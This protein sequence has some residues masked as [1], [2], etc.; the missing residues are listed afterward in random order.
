MAP[1]RTNT[2][3]LGTAWLSGMTS[4]RLHGG[5]RVAPGRECYTQSGAADLAQI[6]RPKGEQPLQDLRTDI[7]PAAGESPRRRPQ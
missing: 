7:G 1:K 4:P 5:E 3:G 2:V 6:N